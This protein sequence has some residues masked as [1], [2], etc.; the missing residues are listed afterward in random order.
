MNNISI[1]R[2]ILITMLCIVALSSCGTLEISDKDKKL[3]KQG[4]KSLL[5]TSNFT[6]T[7]SIFRKATLDIAGDSS[8]DIRQVTINIISIDGKKVNKKWHQANEEVSIEPGKHIIEAE[9]TLDT[10]S[11]LSPSPRSDTQIIDYSFE[12]GKKYK[13]YL[14]E[15]LNH[16]EIGI[17]P[18]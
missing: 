4:K 16:F 13:L 5:V 8:F 14:Q 3:I 12:G 17:K 15:Y 9:Y 10:K 7:E 1:L 18:F 6:L 11:N 2:K